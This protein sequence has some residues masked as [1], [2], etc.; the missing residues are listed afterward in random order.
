MRRTSV[1]LI[2]VTLVTSACAA[3]PAPE[4]TVAWDRVHAVDGVD[5]VSSRDVAIGFLRAYAAEPTDPGGLAAFSG[6]A[7]FERWAH[8]LDVQNAEFP[9]K[10]TGDLSIRSIGASLPFPVEG[11]PGSEDILRIIDVQALVTFHLVPARGDPFDV[12]RV[13]DG[14]MQLLREGPAEWSV[15]EF[16]RDGAP[17]LGSIQPLDRRSSSRGIELTL[18]SFFPAPP[19]WQFNVAVT[20]TGSAAITDASVE[21]VG[22]D[23]TKIDDGTVTGSVGGIAAGARHEGILAVPQQPG[24][25]GITLRL[26]LRTRRV[27]VVFDVPLAKT[28]DASR[29]PPVA[30]GPSPSPT[31]TPS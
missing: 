9:G 14:P 28:L 10:V 2:A 3:S 23:G 15:L 13:F 17:F 5:A 11:V 21:L 7:K 30:P 31:P 6:S 22:A 20:N 18:D 1:L 19:V 12:M 8:W 27:A 29:L 25:A 24:L 16:T 26:T 4:R